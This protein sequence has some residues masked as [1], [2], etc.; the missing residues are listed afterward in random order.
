MNSETECFKDLLRGWLA[1]CGV[2]QSSIHSYTT[3][4]HYWVC[5]RCKRYSDEGSDKVAHA[6]GCLAERTER[7]LVECEA[8]K[9]A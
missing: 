6:P 8:G 3:G 4:G 1:E 2:H 5:A 9:E 7:A